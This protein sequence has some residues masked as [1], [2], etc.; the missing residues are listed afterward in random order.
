MKRMQSTM[1]DTVTVHAGDQHVA[2]AP[3]DVVDF[4]QPLGASTLGAELGPHAEQFTAVDEKP[5]KT[6]SKR[7]T[8]VDPAETPA[9][10][11]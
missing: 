5:A 9:P 10:K 7:E 3:G 11:E 2:I 8:P 1:T 6:R 4:D